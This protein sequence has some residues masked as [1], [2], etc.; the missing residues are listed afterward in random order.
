MTIAAPRNRAAAITLILLGVFAVA[1]ALRVVAIA[2][3]NQIDIAGKPFVDDS[4][5][6]FLLGRNLAETGQTRIDSFHV[7]NGFQPLWGFLVALP[8]LFLSDAAAITV[9]Q[10]I[11]ALLNLGTGAIMIVLITDITR[12]RLAGIVI[13]GLWLIIP[14]TIRESI[15]GMETALATFALLLAAWLFR[16]Y[17][18]QPTTRRLIVAA[19]AAGFAA[20]ARVDLGIFTAAV[21]LFLLVYPAGGKGTLAERFRAAVIF[22]GVALIPAIPWVI[23][24]LAIGKSPLPESGTAVRTL[25]T[26]VFRLMP[27]THDN[28]GETTLEYYKGVAV[29]FVNALRD[30]ILWALPFRR[31]VFGELYIGAIVT[32]LIAV[33]GIIRRGY[34][35]RHL[36]LAALMA[37]MLAGAYIF[38]VPS[39]WYFHRYLHPLAALLTIMLG[40]T[41]LQAFIDL[42][43]RTRLWR[44]AGVALA[45]AYVG[46]VLFWG[47]WFRYDEQG[48]GAISDSISAVEYQ[49]A[50]WLNAN[51]VEGEIV[52]SY[53]SGLIGYYLEVRHMNLDGV[54]NADAEAA[55]ANREP[56]RYICESDIAYVVGRTAMLIMFL[57]SDVNVPEAPVNTVDLDLLFSPFGTVEAVFDDPQYE[58]LLDGYVIVRVDPAKCPGGRA[59]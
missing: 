51:A 24:S 12:S 4:Y 6:Y 14:S 15:N 1:I 56:W 9:I 25:S 35:W 59:S 20:M 16:R 29:T 13:A 19:L 33:Y 40:V 44:W 31:G 21:C 47:F 26:T 32:A 39:S 28:Y 27:G 22:G 5:Y 50:Q 3:T 23:Y 57:Y 48:I 55:L 36:V 38:V 37:V 30:Q 11:G 2:N 58:G 43:A 53:Q 7:T 54:V 8:Y 10:V 41:L 46:A 49:A 18:V 34:G 45:V 42:Q 52:G 17:H